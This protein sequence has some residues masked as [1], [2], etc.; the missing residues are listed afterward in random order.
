MLTKIHVRYFIVILLDEFIVIC[1]NKP[2]VSHKPE[3]YMLHIPTNTVGVAPF[4]K[5][6]QQQCK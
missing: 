4:G 6:A 1:S 2:D 5:S 3:V